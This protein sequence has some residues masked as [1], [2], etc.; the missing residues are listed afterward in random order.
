MEQRAHPSPAP[1]TCGTPEH[2]D[3]AASRPGK[4]AYPLPSAERGFHP[5]PHG[6][7]S[8]SLWAALQPLRQVSSPCNESPGPGPVF[9]GFCPRRRRLHSPVARPSWTPLPAASLLL[10][11]PHQAGGPP[12]FPAGFGVGAGRGQSQLGGSGHA[13]FE[14]GPIRSGQVGGPAPAANGSG[15]SCVRS[16][17]LGL[18]GRAPGAS[19]PWLPEAL[20]SRLRP[21]SLPVAG[22]W[23]TV[24]AEALPHA[25]QVRHASGLREGKGETDPAAARGDRKVRAPLPV[26]P[27]APRAGLVFGP[28]DRG[29]DGAGG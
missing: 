4:G 7:D 19:P 16:G 14:P 8:S 21:A 18:L 3:G 11:P 20:G 28:L 17:P 13:P 23:L 29:S 10:L 24:R 15:R 2:P 6:S 9:K 27:G 26:S 25:H 5:G 22:C 1:C 12:R